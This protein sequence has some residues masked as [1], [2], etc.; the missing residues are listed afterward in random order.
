MRTKLH[1]L[2]NYFSLSKGKVIMMFLDLLIMITS[3][4]MTVIGAMNSQIP[5][6][7]TTISLLIFLIGGFSMVLITA[8]IYA[9]HYQEQINTLVQAILITKKRH[10][11]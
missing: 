9:N 11:N 7:I 3:L 5:L 10:N 2:R 4:V 1:V 6:I 8:L